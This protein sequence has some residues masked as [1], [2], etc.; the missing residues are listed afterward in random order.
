VIELCD[1]APR[2]EAESIPVTIQH[3][4]SSDSSVDGSE[5]IVQ[6]ILHAEGSGSDGAPVDQVPRPTDNAS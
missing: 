3:L 5:D 2:E 6:Q 1:E 4:Q